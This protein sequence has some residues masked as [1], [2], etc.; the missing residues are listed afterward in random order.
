MNIKKMVRE[1]LLKKPKRVYEYGCVM[2]GLDLDG[3]EWKNIQGMIDEDDIYH[4]DKE[5]GTDG[6]FGREL[7]PHVTVLFGVHANV[8]DEDVE[9]IIDKCKK[10]EVELQKIST[11]DNELF[12]VLK[13]DVNSPDLHE[14]NELFKKLPY[15]TEYPNYHPHATICYLKKGMGKKYKEKM[16]N[17]DPIVV[18]PNEIL[19]SKPD[20]TKKRYKI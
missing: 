5:S 14:L 13:F 4:G 2:V 1:S 17:I 19:Y 16:K 15:T 8:P 6:G 18:K 20:G 3:K 7:D 10:P 11:F 12:D 9:K